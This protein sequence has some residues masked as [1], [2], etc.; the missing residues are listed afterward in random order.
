[1]FKLLRRMYDWVLSFANKKYGTLSLFLI[2]FI[3]SSCFPI[4]PDIL[5]IALAISMPTKAFKYALVATIGSVLGGLF[6]YF[7]GYGLYE[8]IG[9]QIIEYF[10]YQD[11]FNIV[12]NFYKENAFLAIITAAFTPI[13]YKVFTIAAGVFRMKMPGFIIASIIGRGA[14]FFIV[15]FLTAKFGELMVKTFDKYLLYFTVIG[16]VILIIF[17]IL[18]KDK[19]KERWNKIIEYMF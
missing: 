3:G 11:V 14:R 18:K 15:A 1:M 10:N 16:V 17:L 5:L 19:I 7:I 6:G 9:V 12:G 13:P 4:P 2:A 8:S